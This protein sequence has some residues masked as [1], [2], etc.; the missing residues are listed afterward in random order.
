MT[1]FVLTRA[2]QFRTP[3]PP[4]LD[5]DEYTAAFLEVQRLGGNGVPGGTE[6]ERTEEQTFIGTFWAY[7]GTPS[8]CAPPR[9]YNQIAVTLA[10]QKKTRDLELARLLALVNLALADTGIATWE[11][12]YFY[13]FWRPITGIREAASDG[14]PDTVADPAWA[15]LLGTPAFPAYTSGHSMVSA[16]SAVVLADFFG[17]D[18]VSFTLPSQNPV[19][20]A[21]S[22]TSFSE[23]AAESAVS[24]LYGGIHWSF[25]NNVGL[26][27][28]ARAQLRSGVGLS[29]T[30]DRL[31]CL[32]GDAHRIDFSD[33]TRGLAVRLL[34]PFHPAAAPHNAAAFQVA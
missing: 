12:K 25:D 33:E 21:R 34:F 30:R 7:D 6:T 23:A 19:L 9:L 24:R 27:A 11:S 31:E 20:A 2:N 10:K 13:Q 14:N 32:Y 28:G 18:N 1:P 5:S 8:L 22:F 4:E 17:T 29:N 3:P 16:A 15:P 26:T